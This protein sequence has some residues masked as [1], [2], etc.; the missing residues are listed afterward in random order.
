MENHQAPKID[1]STITIR[2]N[3]HIARRHQSLC[4]GFF[5]KLLDFKRLRENIY[6]N[7]CRKDLYQNA[8]E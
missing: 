8:P 4:K 1:R 7:V 5:F 3:H 2:Q 6:V